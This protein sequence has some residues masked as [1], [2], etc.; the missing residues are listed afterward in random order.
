MKKSTYIIIAVVFVLLVAAGFLRFVV[1]G[2]EDTWLCDNGQ[3]AKH[4]D[5]SASKPTSGCGNTNST[6]VNSDAAKTSCSINSDC[7]L[8][9]CTGCFNK[10]Y[11]KTAPADLA[12]RTYEGRT[13]VCTNNVCTVAPTSA[14]NTNNAV[15]NASNTNSNINVQK[16]DEN[17]AV[18]ANGI[19]VE[20]I[21]GTKFCS[22]EN[23]PEFGY[24]K[25][26]K[27]IYQDGKEKT[28][29]TSSTK[30]S[31]DNK[32]ACLFIEGVCCPQISP[33]GKYVI[34]EKTGWEWSKP[35]MLNIE[36]GKYVFG[37]ESDISVITDIDWSSD[38]KNFAI[39]T[40]S[41]E[42]LGEG[43]VEV[44]VSAYNNP[45][46]IKRA[47]TAENSIVTGVTDVH[48]IRNDVI[49][50][51]IEQQSTE[52]VAQKTLNYEYNYHTNLLTPLP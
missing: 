38:N 11:L 20:V 25:I 40:D 39:T 30:L 49:Q 17:S 12:C 41:N 22:I 24:Q 21:N 32:D 37:D 23:N 46:I 44:Y 10:E 1:G 28:L 18:S 26:L 29:Y 36:T 2:D 5:P 33:D 47:W 13:C 4:G 6:A 48:F 35:Y 27:A 19:R 43:A 9:I 42:F 8:R 3:W 52:N 16:S 31:S 34:F 51:T 50:I 14:T 7:K 15:N 45:E